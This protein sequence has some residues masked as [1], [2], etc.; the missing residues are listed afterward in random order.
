MAMEMPLAS[1]LYRHVDLRVDTNVLKEFKPCRWRQYV[2]PKRWY[3]PPSPHDDT[4]NVVKY[5]LVDKIKDDVMG[6]ACSCI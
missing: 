1:G 6:G 5:L 3:L 4:T 2:P